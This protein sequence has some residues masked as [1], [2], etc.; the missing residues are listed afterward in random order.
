MNIDDLRNLL[1]EIEKKYDE[2]ERE[3]IENL[4]ILLKE[5]DIFFRLDL[6][7]ALGILNFLGIPENKI[8]DCYLSLISPENF[9]EVGLN[10]K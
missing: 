6:E 8:Y 7:V 9:Q 10:V 4:K 2:S 1:T 3:K 5:D